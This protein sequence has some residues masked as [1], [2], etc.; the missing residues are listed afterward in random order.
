MDLFEI[1]NATHAIASTEVILP[2]GWIIGA[3]GTLCGAI[4]GLAG[5]MWSFVTKRLEEQ[6]VLIRRQA[7]TIARLQDD[8]E[9][10]STGCGAD[11]CHWRQRGTGA[12]QIARNGH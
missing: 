12:I 1:A 6:D 4:A 8:I 2:I 7:E 3:I 9:R 11:P 5:V 10:M